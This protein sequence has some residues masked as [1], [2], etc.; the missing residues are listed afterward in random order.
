METSPTDDPRVFF[1][2]VCSHKNCQRKLPFV[3]SW[4]CQDANPQHGIFLGEAQ[5][6]KVLPQRPTCHV[7]CFPQLAQPPSHVPSPRRR[8]GA[9][10]P[11]HKEEHSAQG[12]LKQGQLSNLYVY[13]PYI[14]IYICV[15][16]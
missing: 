13:K 8:N 1:Q 11:P 2:A 5:K 16:I 3:D 7:C 6:L 9:V 10:R 12:C 15:R 4:G 14:R